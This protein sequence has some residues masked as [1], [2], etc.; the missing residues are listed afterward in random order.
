M[1]L[2]PTLL[3]VMH[4]AG[5]KSTALGVVAVTRNG[6]QSARGKIAGSLYFKECLF[7][8]SV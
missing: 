2:V 7:M 5:Q 6:L 3:R 1:L 8:Q 4:L